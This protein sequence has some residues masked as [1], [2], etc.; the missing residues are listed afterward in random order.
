MML[1]EVPPSIRDRIEPEPN[2]GCWI[3]TG[4]LITDGYARIRQG[5]RKGPQLLVHRYLYELEHGPIRAGLV[6]DHLCRT[7][8]CVNPAH[9][10]VVTDLENCRRGLKVSLKTTCKHGHPWVPENMLIRKRKS[11]EIYHLCR[12]CKR[13]ASAIRY[14]KDPAYWQRRR[15]P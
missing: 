3:W 14:A 9:I 10:E 4:Y 7:T 13:I 6:S 11:G 12:E 8:C 5:G 2:S 1:S 15:L